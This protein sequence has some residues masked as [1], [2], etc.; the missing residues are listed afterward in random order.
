MPSHY[1]N[2]KTVNKEDLIKRY[3]KGHVVITGGAQGIGYAYAEIL[4][5]IFDLI[6][7]EINEEKLNTAVHTL[8]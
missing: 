2:R 8:K 3:G 7:V 5:P 6:L 4:A 1:A